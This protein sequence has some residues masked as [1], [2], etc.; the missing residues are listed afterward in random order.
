ME[1]L[2]YFIKE[3]EQRYRCILQGDDH[4]D[5]AEGE[6]GDVIATT[7]GSCWNLK[8]HVS[9]KHFKV[10]HSHL[11]SKSKED[12][13]QKACKEAESSSFKSS[14][15]Q[16]MTKMNISQERKAELDQAFFKMIYMDYEP[17]TK[18]EREGM[19]YFAQ[20]A[21]P[22]YTPPCNN[23]IRDTLMPHALIEL[24]N[25]LSALLK[26]CNGLSVAID[27]W[28]S[29]RGHSFLGIVASFIDENFKCH[30]VLL[31]CEQIQAHHTAK[32]I[33]EKYEE[34]LRRWN[35]QHGVI[36]VITDSASNMV[37]AFNLPGFNEF[38]DVLD[39]DV[40]VEETEVEIDA[41]DDALS[42][43]RADQ[44]ANQLN[45]MIQYY[46]TETNL[47]LRCPIHLL[48]LAIKDA[49]AKHNAV[50]S[51][52]NK[53]G[54]VVKTV[55]KSTLNTDEIDKLA[56]PPTTACATRWSGQ[57]RMIES[58]LKM[59]ENDALWQNRLTSIP[60][61]GKITRSDVLMLQGLVRV[62]TP[63]AELTDSLQKELGN[64]G[65]ILP[66][67][68]EI[69]RMMA[70]VSSPLEVAAF[71]ETLAENFSNRYKRFYDDTHVVLAALLDPRFKNEWIARDEKVQGKQM[72]IR[73]LLV[74]QTQLLCSVNKKE[75]FPLVVADPEPSP[76]KKAK[77]MFQSYATATD[78][79]AALDVKGEIEQYLAMPRMN[80]DVDVLRFWKDNSVMLPRLSH[81][82]RRI[83]SIP[84][85]SASLERV[86]SIAG[87]M[88][89][90]NR[91]RS[92]PDTLQ[93]LVFLKVNA[94]LEI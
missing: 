69:R 93:K 83:F 46:I 51:V 4:D 68:A 21:Q 34:V 88:S 6:C 5:Q 85:G 42:Q 86:F 90:T 65:M 81:V 78:S 73:E 72:E 52:I 10:F 70:D 84:S 22:G 63:F 41:P 19:R 3:S 71:A 61:D 64:L 14:F 16:R 62:L 92:T 75:T 17:L 53:I 77:S 13:A 67:V 26:H 1:F 32:H 49:I 33:Y 24:E 79:S 82:A 40:K 47:H 60:D 27:I 91:M 57:L 80:P 55:R 87:L 11:E 15:P 9:R 39:R 38:G 45:V 56:V 36:R 89:N 18:G 30:T 8:R 58:L 31:S 74:H 59:F 35:V 43:L 12:E 44:L 76:S 48:Q 37:K 94:A 28:T 20:I 50:K 54:K 25:K 2:K 7:K 29:R 23:T 66:A